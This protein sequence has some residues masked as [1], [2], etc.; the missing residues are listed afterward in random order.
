MELNDQNLYIS[1]T[2]VSKL[3]SI[4]RST[5]LKLIKKDE[6]PNCF[7]NSK[8]E[9]YRIPVTDIEAYKEK[10][11][12]IEDAKK[13]FLSISEMA[14]ISG[15]TNEKIR[16]DLRNGKIKKFSRDEN[17]NYIVH[18]DIFDEYIKEHIERNGF[19]TLNEAC[20]RLSLSKLTIHT[21]GP[22]KVFP[23]AIIRNQTEGYLI[24]ISDIEDYENKNVIPEG[25]VTVKQIAEKYKLHPETIRG[26]IRNNVLKNHKKYVKDTYIVLASEAEDYFKDMLEIKEKY[27]NIDEVSQ[28]IG[29]NKDTIRSYIKKGLIN[30]CILRSNS[31]G[32]LI[33]RLEIDK[34]KEIYS[35]ERLQLPTGYIFPEDVMQLLETRSV[36]RAREII[37]KHMKSA[38]K[39]TNGFNNIEYWIVLESEVIQY[40]QKLENDRFIPQ[41][42]GEFTIIDAVNKYKFEVDKISIPLKLAQTVKIYT[43][44]ACQKL[45]ESEARA[46]TLSKKT[47]Y[48]IKTLKALIKHLPKSIKEMTDEDIESFLNNE[49]QPKYVK[50]YF[51]GFVQYCSENIEDCNFFNRYATFNDPNTDTDIYSL[52]TFN[53]YYNHV[54]DIELHIEKAIKYKTYAQAWVYVIMHLMNAWRSGDII[55][56]LPTIDF[57]DLPIKDLTFFENNRLRKEEA[58]LIVNQVHIKVG[59]MK[60]S[61]TGALGQFLCLD[62]LV[63]PFA[64]AI[65]ITELHR[66]KYN[67]KLMLTSIRAN[68]INKMFFE[69][70]L[71][72]SGFHSVKMNR[73]LITYFFH[74]VSESDGDAH[75]SYEAAQILRSHLNEDTTKVY[76]KFSSP[77]GTLDSMAFNI[78]ERGH[79]G[80]VYNTMI[81]L[82]LHQN[83]QK[84]EDRTSLI[85]SLSEKY[86]VNELETYSSFL[87]AERIKKESLALRLSKLPK[88]D[89]KRLIVKIFRGEMPARMA[90]AQCLTYPECKSPERTTCIG[91]ENLIPTEYLLFSISEQIETSLYKIYNSEFEWDKEREKHFLKQM[92]LLMNEAIVEKGK[93]YVETFIDRKRIKKLY[94][95][96]LKDREVKQIDNSE[97][98]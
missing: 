24:P 61:K 22:R 9:G 92:F 27:A 14:E 16:S 69:K 8:Q 18:K 64:T 35:Q 56:G 58:R 47:A 30:D 21:Y 65:S 71:E 60:I 20:E 4:N 87:L 26:L 37:K 76:I 54:I 32:Y 2:E 95:A 19:L 84:L 81:N 10:V 91:C 34:I 3:F 75:L 12:K 23:N 72:L 5:V 85:K 40:K 57:V 53:K 88:E 70:K 79:F 93:E 52:E 25:Y 29:C 17:N 90:F 96:I 42:P 89:L 28:I 80:W 36:Q 15:C 48:Y 6:F 45:A 46:E 55:Y 73:T 66:R 94:G 82:V 77:Q 49:S 11:T 74:H 1:V 78:C 68:G 97:K 43:E 41:S 83:E 86:K 63:E 98:G 50:Q 13:D 51:I 67:D 59:Q 33:N 31:E 44:Y 38:K 7:I 62:S 39:V